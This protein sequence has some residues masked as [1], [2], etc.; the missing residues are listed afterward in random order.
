MTDE[1]ELPRYR[2]TTPPGFFDG[3][4]LH[5]V[6][7]EIDWEPSR[8]PYAPSVTFQPLNRAGADRQGKEALAKWD[9][10]NTPV[11]VPAKK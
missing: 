2:V 11:T 6:D 5:P 10:Q 7:T 9:A 3:G 8:F 1:K 4:Q